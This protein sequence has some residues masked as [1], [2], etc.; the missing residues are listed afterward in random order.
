M[1]IPAKILV[2]EDHLFFRAMLVEL[3]ENQPDMTVCGQADN[4]TDALTLIAQTQPD[5]AL[6]DLTLN[7][8]NGLDLIRHLTAGNVRLPVLV[9][10]MHPQSLHAER[11]MR[12][13]A[14]GYVSKDESPDAVIAAMRTVLADESA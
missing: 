3:I 12:A 4:V 7:G 9:L 14:W 6:V 13:G 11:A 5:V 2:V 8:S 1:P 10:S